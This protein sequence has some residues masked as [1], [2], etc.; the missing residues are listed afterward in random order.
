M[1]TYIA[2][3]RGINVS[4]HNKIKMVELKQL[5]V[6]LGFFEV[7]TYIQSGNVIFLSEQTEIASIEQQIINAIK[8]IFDYTINVLVLTKIDLIT[9]FKSNPFLERNT[10][11]ITKLHITILKNEPDTEGIFE[12]SKFNYLNDDK[13]IIH[14]KSIYLLCPNGS[15]NTKLTN[16]LFEN[17]L[18]TSATT[19]NWRTITKLVELSNPKVE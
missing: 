11:D 5:F 9:I 7:V 19:R 14:H 16:N 8:Q 13:F 12:L 18:K 15:G 17:K 6:D 2:L 4:G 10:I 1:K 3:L